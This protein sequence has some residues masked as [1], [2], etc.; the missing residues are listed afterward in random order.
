M[1]REVDPDVYCPQAALIDEETHL[2]TERRLA[3]YRAKVEAR[4]Q[5][6]RSMLALQR[7]RRQLAWAAAG[8]LA[9]VALGLVWYKRRSIAKRRRR[10]GDGGLPRDLFLDEDDGF[11]GTD[12]ELKQLF[13]EAAKVARAFPDGMLDQRDQLMLYGL[14]K[15]AR[16]GDRHDDA[17]STSC[18]SF[19]IGNFLRSSANGH[20]HSQLRH[21]LCSH[22]S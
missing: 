2:R 22:R 7:Q 21:K 13:E 3:R 12:E 19:F 1:R 5:R 10:G 17:V 20:V 14:Y 6:E 8:T 16:E 15:Q 9:A 4:K 11:S 18:A